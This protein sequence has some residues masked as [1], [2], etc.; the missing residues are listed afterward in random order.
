[1]AGLGLPTEPLTTEVLARGGDVI[2]ETVIA[3]GGPTSSEEGARELIRLRVLTE[4]QGTFAL[5]EPW[6]RLATSLAL[7]QA[8]FDVHVLW[9]VSGSEIEG[10]RV[11]VLQGGAH[12]LLWIQASE[13]LCSFE[14][15]SSIEFL[16]RLGEMLNDGAS[17]SEA[18]PDLESTGSLESSPGGSQE[19]NAW[20]PTHTAPDLGLEA[21]SAPGGAGAAVVAKLD[22]FLEVAVDEW[23]GG[24]ARIVCSNGWSAWVDARLLVELSSTATAMPMPISE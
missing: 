23:T 5:A 9:E 22:P 7:I 4:A 8:S 10:C 18:R 13:G 14:T 19:P 3:L 17:E 11:V 6:R 1:L 20:R 15:I 2:S 12:D 21:W 24:W 16:Y